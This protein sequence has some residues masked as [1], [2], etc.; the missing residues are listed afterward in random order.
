MD[1]PPDLVKDPTLRLKILKNLQP[2]DQQ[3]L[4]WE[5][6]RVIHECLTD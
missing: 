2:K 3:I 4:T 6:I 1:E 5:Q